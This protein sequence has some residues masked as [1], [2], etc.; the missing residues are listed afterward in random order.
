MGFTLKNIYYGVIPTDHCLDV[1]EQ[2]MRTY[3][4]L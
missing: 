2:G 3:L 4:L 1:L